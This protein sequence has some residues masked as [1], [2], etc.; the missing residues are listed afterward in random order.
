MSEHPD[1]PAWVRAVQVSHE[2]AL[3][4][5]CPTFVGMVMLCTISITVAVAVFNYEARKSISVD[6]Y[7]RTFGP[8][9][10]C[11]VA[12]V[13]FGCL[14]FFAVGMKMGIMFWKKQQAY[15]EG[16]KLRHE[17]EIK[18]RTYVDGFAMMPGWGW[19]DVIVVF[20]LYMLGEK[21]SAWAV[22][23]TVLGIAIA[24]ALFQMLLEH[25]GQDVEKGG[26]LHS[27]IGVCSASFAVGVG[28][29]LNLFFKTVIVQYLGLWHWWSVRLAYTL[30]ITAFVTWGQGKANAAFAEE[31]FRKLNPVI[32]KTLAFIV[33]SAKFLVGWAWKGLLDLTVG[34]TLRGVT[35]SP[36]WDQV[37]VSFT[38]T[39]LMFGG[40]GAA[41]ATESAH[42]REVAMLV[43]GMIIGWTW[44][45]TWLKCGYVV[46]ENLVVLWVSASIVI[47]IAAIIAVLLD[48]AFT[49]TQEWIEEHAEEMEAERQALIAKA[50][51]ARRPSNLTRAATAGEAKME[52]ALSGGA[53]EARNLAATLKKTKSALV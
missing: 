7:D 39:F 18:Y 31:E 44:A 34:A 13:I 25:L 28:Y 6:I 36:C 27:S 10:E 41:L 40:V 52:A 47:M 22:S 35:P 30:F 26:F 46:K 38:T 16:H 23:L 24:S 21:P 29:A 15:K 42:A 1:H 12:L 14:V 17:E 4:K 3:S 20:T 43:A 2:L 8:I 33:N 45:Q 19:K 48:I 37:L 50:A 51:K 11:L 9:Q 53:E 5:V 49:K 32:Q